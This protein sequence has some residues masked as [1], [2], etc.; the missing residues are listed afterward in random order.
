[1]ARHFTLNLRGRL[2]SL[3][4]PMVMGILN[5]TPDSFYAA[6]RQQTED[7]IRRR[8]RRMTTEGADI[9]DVGACSSR[10][11][12]ESGDGGEELQR[13]GRGL[14]I[15]REEAPR[16]VV[17]VD[18]WRADVARMAVEEAGADMVNDI[19]G[20]TLDD[21][22]FATVARMGVPYVLTHMRGTPQT[23]QTVAVYDDVAR[24]VL[25]FL[26]ERI[27]CLHELG[28]CDII[29]DP[30]F[31]FA[32][33]LGHNYALMARLADFTALDAPLL[34][35]VSRKSMI[36]RLLGTTPEAALNGTTAL[37]MAAL[38]AGAHILRVHDVR[39][40]VEC[41]RIH[42]EIRKHSN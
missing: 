9:I 13:L 38:A 31:G 11:G 7:E 29:A 35:G 16:A 26:Q 14:R 36:Y 17:S 39:E 18:T 40:A 3:D 33:T 19:S 10:P 41:V 15:V 2:V 23:M 24:D 34:V 32:K 30:G 37:H 12:A 6:S 1:M 42:A 25:L 28:V 4:R 20:G 8:V 21:A 27:D 5:L 22:M